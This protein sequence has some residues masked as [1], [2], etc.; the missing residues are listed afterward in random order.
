MAMAGG[1][2]LIGATIFETFFGTIL[3]PEFPAREFSVVDYGAKGDGVTTNTAAFRAAVEACAK[4]GGGTVVIPKGEYLAGPIRLASDVRLDFREATVVFTDRMDDY[5]PPV[6]VN[7]EGTECLNYSPLVYA[8]D[9][10]NVALTGSGKLVARTDAWFARLRREERSGEL[11]VKTDLVRK[12]GE[13]GVPLAERDATR[14]PGTL[15]PPLLLF[16]RCRNVLI[17][18]IGYEQSPMWCYHL[19]HCENVVC[20][21]FRCHA[22]GNNSDGI[23]PEGTRNM[24][25]E[26]V[27]FDVGDD[28][29]AV[30]SGRDYD[31]R[32]VGRATENLE[33]RRCTYLNG[34]SMLACGSELSGGI[35]N[36][37]AHDNK[38]VNCA[39]LCFLKSNRARGGIVENVRISDVDV[40]CC[41][42]QLCGLSLKYSPNPYA[43]AK[44][45]VNH[46]VFR[47]FTLENVKAKYCAHG[48]NIEATADN[49]ASGFTFRNISVGRA[50]DTNLRFENVDDLT[51]DGVKLGTYRPVATRGVLALTF[52]DREPMEGWVRAL[53]LFEKYGAHATFF[54]PGHF[55][56][57]TVALAKTLE[58]AGHTIGLHG[59]NHRR[60]AHFLA[61]GG[62]SEAYIREEI[63]PQLSEARAAG[64]NP[65]FWAYPGNDCDADTDYRI[66]YWF[67]RR[68]RAGGTMAEATIPVDLLPH[69][70]SWRRTL[71][72][73]PLYPSTDYDALL[74]HLE[75]VADENLCLSTFSHHIAENPDRMSCSPHDLERLL[76]RCR[77]LGIRVLG[78]SALGD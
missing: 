9:A 67:F 26:N 24:L 47:N 36:V 3:A 5:L 77:E 12:W 75:K 39:A 37:W 40:D 33:V 51:V 41:F 7:W 53:P 4:A 38:V 11:K 32:R 35:R 29:M 46:T 19:V 76:K 30:K 64:F 14:G 68:N 18:G 59:L 61:E 48:I 50:D 6:E 45:G 13:D 71:H 57:K 10:T 62:T 72:A 52:D 31:G 70:G 73:M 56:A 1:I 49:R 65:K 55:D 78:F 16:K 63:E 27:V 44:H 23:D 8:I 54:I 42:V 60:A 21:N 28:C 25:V 17:E 20:R 58:A 66:A 34:H 43:I 69:R 22:R 74:K 15:R 2:V